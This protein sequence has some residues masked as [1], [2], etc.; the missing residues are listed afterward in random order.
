M[1]ERFQDYSWIHDFEAR[2][3]PQNTKLMDF[4]SKTLNF[5]DQNKISD[6]LTY[7]SKLS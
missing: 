6:L 7:N 4:F 5:A 2:S 1:D 3:Q